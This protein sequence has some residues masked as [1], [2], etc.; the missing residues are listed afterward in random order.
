MNNSDNLNFRGKY[1]QYDPDG[2]PYLYKI[3]DSVEYVGKT[4]VSI[5]PNSFKIPNTPES[6]DVW[7]EL[8]E[9]QSF[10]ISENVPDAAS[11][12]DR[13]YKPTDGI[14]YTLVEEVNNKFWV[15]F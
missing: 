9:N 10:F 13:W 8:S 14:V 6:R 11:I 15:E 4:Y 2:K 5:K 3:G 12:G 7:K 1:K